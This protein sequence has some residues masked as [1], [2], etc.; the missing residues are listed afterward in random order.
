MRERQRAQRILE[1]LSREFSV[2]KIAVSSKDVF[3]TLVRTV[4]SQATND[5][6]RDRAYRNLA[7]RYEISPEALAAA[8]VKAIEEAIRVGGLYRN[9]ARKLKALSNVV[10]ERFKGSLDFIYSEPLEKARSMLMSIPGVG[11]KTADVVL[12]FAAGKPTVPVD[13]HV[14]RVSRR[15]GLAPLRGS[16]EDIRGALESLY[17][18]EDYLAIHLL[19]IGLGRWFCRARNPLHEPCPLRSLCPVPKR[20]KREPELHLKH[21][22]RDYP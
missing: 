9:K 16:Y 18:P 1:V 19:L 12:L 4:L 6:N 21:G 5:R 3:P 15:L 17:S 7:D 11:P 20:E 14:H 8:D 10:V 22:S 13:T 2:P